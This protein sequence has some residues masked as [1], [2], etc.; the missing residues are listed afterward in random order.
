MF[1]GSIVALVTPMTAD[2][3]VDFDSLQQLVAFHLKQG[4]DGLV[5]MGTTGE[6]ATL[7]MAEQHAVMTKVCAQVAGKI[8]VLAGNGAMATSDAIAKTQFFADFL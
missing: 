8:P 1:S 7:S 3:Q 6:A 4:S 2:G 5:I